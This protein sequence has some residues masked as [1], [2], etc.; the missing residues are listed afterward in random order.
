MRL[1]TKST[2]TAG[3]QIQGEDFNR[4][5]QQLGELF[6]QH[7]DEHNLPCS[8]IGPTKLADRTNPGVQE[9]DG[10]L[11]DA[12]SYVG[13]GADWTTPIVTYSLATAST[14]SGWNSL[15]DD[16][17]FARLEVL[18]QPGLLRGEAII[19]AERRYGYVFPTYTSPDGELLWVS[20]GLFVDGQLVQQTGPIYPRRYTYCLPWFYYTS[21]GTHVLEIKY[22][23]LTQD[24]SPLNSEFTQDLKIYTVG[25][26]LIIRKR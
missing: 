23:A 17:S 11:F 13:S 4:E 26:N 16:T 2:F 6:N 25:H 18:A 14:V 5:N 8:T 12:V 9:S 20:F 7:I 10:P 19:D 3:A 22:Q 1:Y 15:A 21:G 24:L